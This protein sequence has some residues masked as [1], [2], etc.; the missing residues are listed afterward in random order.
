MATNKR[1]PA[2]VLCLDKNGDEHSFSMNRGSIKDWSKPVWINNKSLTEIEE[3][4]PNLELDAFIRNERA[5]NALTN[6][7]RIIWFASNNNLI[8]LSTMY[9]EEEAVYVI[10][11]KNRSA[12]RL[13]TVQAKSLAECRATGQNNDGDYVLPLLLTKRRSKL[14]GLNLY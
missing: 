7:V 11:T 1:G 2:A 4:N 8:K 3:Y 13:V 9:P 6:P 12:L 14:V 10:F 5:A